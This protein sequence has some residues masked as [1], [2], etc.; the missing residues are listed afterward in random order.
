MHKKRKSFRDLSHVVDHFD[1]ANKLKNKAEA[2][3]HKAEEY[4]N[5]GKIER[6]RF[7]HVQAY[8]LLQEVNFHFALGMGYLVKLL[9]RE[10]KI[11]RHSDRNFKRGRI[12]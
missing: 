6:A 8:G 4:F 7:C 5:L 9:K 11:R 1:Y 3:L 2:W 10:K 12:T